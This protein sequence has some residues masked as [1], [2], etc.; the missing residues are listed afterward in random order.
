MEETLFHE[1]RQIIPFLAMITG[2]VTIVIVGIISSQND[3]EY[4]EGRDVP[5]ISDIGAYRPEWYVFG[6]G[7]TISCIL[8]LII[9]VYHYL[10]LSRLELPEDKGP[11]I[12]RKLYR[13]VGV[14]LNTLLLF[15]TAICL[16]LLAWFN[17]IDHEDP[18]AIFTGI[19][20]GCVVVFIVLNS[21]LWAYIH[22]LMGDE[23]IPRLAL[24]WKGIT[25]IALLLFLLTLGGLSLPSCVRED[26]YSEGNDSCQP[27]RNAQPIFQYLA[28]LCIL[29]FVSSLSVELGLKI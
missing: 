6:V 21:V 5:W 16:S 13:I 10:G 15:V 24:C 22:F 14:Y 29:I 27:I 26:N 4:S 7:M 20:F 9:D 17:N 11:P 19:F 12:F 8:T 23:R 3:R 18:H 2:I 1:K 25:A 28:T